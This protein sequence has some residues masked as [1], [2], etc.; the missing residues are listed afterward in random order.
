MK[1]LRLKAFENV[2]NM[3]E[4]APIQDPNVPGFQVSPEPVVQWLV[5][6]L[7]LH[8]LLK[9]ET[10]LSLKLDGR[11]FFGKNSHIFLSTFVKGALSWISHVRCDSSLS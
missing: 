5:R 7:R 9:D 6:E 11:P 3:L 4:I 1:A 10:E 8:G 2:Q